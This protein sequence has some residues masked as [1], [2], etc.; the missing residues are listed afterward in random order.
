[1]GAE[2]W[3][4][5]DRIFHDALLKDPSERQRF[6]DQACGGDP[7]LKNEVESLLRSHEQTGG[8]LE[9]SPSASADTLIGRTLGSYSVKSLLG[10]GGMG[11]VYRAWDSR[12]KRDVAI[13]V[14]PDEFSR[15]TERVLRFQR[16]AEMLAALNQPHIAAIYDLGETN[17][18]RQTNHRQP[19]RES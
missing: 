3:N 14:L 9:S 7:S 5:I 12:L 8:I 17:V 15:D 18:V 2:E 19:H 10:A 6:L 11:A 1:V 4:R 16:E 13:K